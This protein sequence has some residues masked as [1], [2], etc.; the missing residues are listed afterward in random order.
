[1]TLSIDGT[2]ISATGQATDLAGN[3]GTVTASGINLDQT[4]PTG[5][6]ALNPP[7]PPNG[8]YTIVPV[9]ATFAC[10][11]TGSGI[12]TCP[13]PQ[14][15]STQGTGLQATG[16]AVDLAGNFT[17]LSSATFAIQLTAPTITV[18]LSPTANSAGWNN[19]PVTAHFT[20][21]EGG[22][23]I[24]NCPA[25]IVT[26][27]EGANQ[28]VT[29]SVTSPSGV[30]VSVTS[31]P[32]SIDLTPPTVVADRAPAPNPAGW[33]NSSVTVQFTCGD[34]LS[35]VAV[36]PPPQPVSTEGA[37]QVVTA[38]ATDQAGNVIAATTAVNLDKTPPSLTLVAPPGGTTVFVQNPTL[39]GTATDALSGVASAICNG[40]QATIAGAT[41]TCGVSLTPGA[42]IVVGVA[43]DRAGNSS[44]PSTLTLQYTR[45]PVVTLTQP[46]N[47]SYLNISPTT[48][49]GTVD[50]PT[51]T[52]EINGIAAVVANGT[53]SIA[54]PLA[55]GPNVIAATAATP[56]GAAGTASIQVTLDTTPPH[57]TI[58]SPRDQFDTTEDTVSISGIINDIVVGTVN[59]QQAQV[60]VNGTDAQVANRTFLAQSVPLVVGPNVIQAVARDRVGNMATTQITI[61]R[62][63]PTAQ[64]RIHAVSGNAQTAVIR[65]AVPSPL[66]VRLT[67]A[68]GA[69][70][71]NKS[72][73]FKVTQNDGLVAS[74]AQP[75]ATAVATTDAQGVAQVQWTLGGR[76]GAGG[77]VV[78]AY[79]VGADGTAIFT[80]TGSLGPAGLVVVDTG[81]NQI[82]P[83]GQALPKP[84]IAVVV[85]GGNNRLAG[86]PVTFTVGQGGGSF[87]GQQD[88]TVVTD[89]DGRAAATLTL[90]QQEGEANNLVSATFASNQGFP[91]AFT[92]SGLAPGDP[93]KTSISGVVLDNSNQP[94][95][96]VTVRAVLTNVATSN[97]NATL[98]APSAATDA[99]G[100][101]T[102][103]QAPVGSVELFVDG[104]TATTPGAFPSLEYDLVTVAG[105]S[106][107]VGQPI[108]LLP[109]SASNQLC[110]TQ[111]TGGGTLTIAEA[112]GFSLTFAPGQVTFPGG[113]RTG[114]VSV[115]VVHPD[116]V[117][118]APGFGQQPRFIVTIQPSGAVFNPPAAITLPNVDGL[119]PRSVTEMYSFDHDISSFVAIGT[120]TVS[121]DGTLIRSSSGVGVLKAGWHCGGNPQLLGATAYCAACKYCP[122]GAS[123]A[124]LACVPDPNQM[125]NACS[126][127][128]NECWAGTCGSS[129]ASDG[130]GVIKEL[131]TGYCQGVPLTGTSCTVSGQQ[132]TCS[133]GVCVLTCDP[134]ACAGTCVSGGCVCT[135]SSCQTTCVG[136][137][138]PPPCSTYTFNGSC[139][140]SQ[141]GP[142]D[143]GRY[144][145]AGG[146]PTQRPGQCDA[147]GSC[148]GTGSQ[149]SSS[150][151]P[152]NP[153]SCREYGCTDGAC[154][155]RPLIT[156]GSVTPQSAFNDFNG[157]PIVAYQYQINLNAPTGCAAPA[158]IVE[159]I[160]DLSRS[161][162]CPTG[163]GSFDALGT[164]FVFNGQLVYRDMIGIV[165]QPYQSFVGT[166][167]VIRRQV[168]SLPFDARIGENRLRISITGTPTTLTINTCINDVCQPSPYTV[169]K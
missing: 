12:A 97:A 22:A 85:D 117:P 132:G 86:V 65:T 3:V 147:G 157:T 168:I 67:D 109:L 82:G 30:T 68:N 42:N 26:S 164:P 49:S 105:Q 4:A 27:T 91:A 35:G 81:N 149:C 120:G 80:A 62:S 127:A 7:L 141:C 76:A 20:C 16:T 107:T 159:S 140:L 166:C 6:V 125:G 40:N 74:S 154:T 87:D 155:S 99:Q 119:A 43:T 150:C 94:I 101:F 57:V 56:S 63:A 151:T 21:Q 36:C 75:A 118:M 33:N 29:G 1:V 112:P 5:S 142:A 59:A 50:D 133:S 102:I 146:G 96:G 32:F 100:Q 34:A 124:D 69:P 78:E 111:T 24:P 60:K 128:S 54:L 9:T 18:D 38:T 71:A 138:C 46:A 123:G 158:L 41:V 93:S 156:I 95:P 48:V 44:A 135:G 139:V 45:V 77:N 72:V 103:A 47:L 143:F 110:V 145:N 163:V 11:D 70:L 83:I 37:N 113:S 115:S 152:P 10:Q 28:T 126:S 58:T 64:P 98:T 15:F 144:C 88:V 66:V 122:G 169:L 39:T 89:S 31:A 61:V 51:A 8:I 23:P 13:Q 108:F 167:D 165:K 148:V 25:D 52:V 116:K 2:N 131:P 90:G 106:T 129:P 134:A 73:I 130:S 121:D 53:F 137:Q 104:S 136:G 84:F 114:C 14:T 55:E 160:T 92:A 153:D 162:G 161:A 19:T 79:S 17:P